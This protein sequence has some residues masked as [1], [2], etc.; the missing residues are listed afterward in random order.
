MC[1]TLPEP[2]FKTLLSLVE[3]MEEKSVLKLI[4]DYNR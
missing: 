4:R 3:T 2:D 1:Y